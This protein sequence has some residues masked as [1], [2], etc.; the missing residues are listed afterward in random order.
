MAAMI[1][2]RVTVP[3]GHNSRIND[4]PDESV[5]EAVVVRIQAMRR[6]WPHEQGSNMEGLASQI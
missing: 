2:L 6:V 5:I 4:H 3:I 1:T